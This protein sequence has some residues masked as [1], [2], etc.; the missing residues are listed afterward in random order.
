[1]AMREEELSK[2]HEIKKLLDRK[3]EL[4]DRTEQLRKEYG[5]YISEVDSTNYTEL[6]ADNESKAYRQNQEIKLIQLGKIRRRLRVRDRWYGFFIS[7]IF[8]GPSLVV[9]LFMMANGLFPV[10][11]LLFFTPVM[12]AFIGFFVWLGD[13]G[14]KKLS[15]ENMLKQATPK[16]K[17][18]LDR[19]EREGQIR[20]NKARAEDNR[21]EKENQRRYE[22]A[23]KLAQVKIQGKLDAIDKER[24]RLDAEIR[25]IDKSIADM[26]LIGKDDL[27]GIDFLIE[28]ISTRRADSLKEALRDLD[29]RREKANQEAIARI[30]EFDAQCER[31]RLRREQERREEEQFWSDM[32]ERERR[33]EHEKKVEDELQRMRQMLEDD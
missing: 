31:D 10:E 15:D 9:N 1:M 29:M 13:R 12:A 16:D 20:L 30:K 21:I 27:W 6:P 14:M 23:K 26:H 4:S 2:L 11:G 18:E 22:E 19:I 25:Q 32:R 3:K 24:N 28:R 33:R 8:V 17:A 7:L 5:R